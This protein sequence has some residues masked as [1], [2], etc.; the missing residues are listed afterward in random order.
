MSASDPDLRSVS[1]IFAWAEGKSIGRII[2]LSAGGVVASIGSGI[3]RGI[4]TV[5]DLVT[6]PIEALGDALAQIVE[7]YF[8]V[9]L[10]IPRQAVQTSVLALAPGATWAIGPFTVFLG[11]LINL[12]VLYII[13][14]YLT[15]FETS[16]VI[17]GAP[18]DLGF[19]PFREEEDTVED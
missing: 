7:V 14:R 15:E 1:G 12:G 3:I 17:P 11:V 9:T 19:W 13:A 2:E 18:F 5:S 10:D 4:I 8:I 16:N 6:N